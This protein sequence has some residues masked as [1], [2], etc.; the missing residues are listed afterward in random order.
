[1][2][3][4]EDDFG[5]CAKL[6]TSSKREREWIFQLLL[7]E[8]AALKIEDANRMFPRVE[9]SASMS[10]NIR[11]IIHRAEEPFFTGEQFQDFLFDPTDGRRW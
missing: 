4:H 8:G 6:F 7:H 1:M 10:W 3:I 11:G 2:E 9:D 5:L